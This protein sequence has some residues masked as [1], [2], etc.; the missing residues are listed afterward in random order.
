M[1]STWK[2]KMT[3]AATST[4]A[5]GH[6]YAGGQP[7][8]EQYAQPEPHAQPEQFD[9]LG[10]YGTFEQPQVRLGCPMYY[11]YCMPQ[12]QPQVPQVQIWY[13]CSQ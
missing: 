3:K 13:N 5:H 12:V 8:P 11:D 1:D 9:G 4:Q 2:G 7:Q 10:A 6:D